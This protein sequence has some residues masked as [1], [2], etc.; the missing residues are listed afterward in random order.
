MTKV[1]NY[2]LVIPVFQEALW[3]MTHNLDFEATHSV[4]LWQRSPY[5]E[6]QSLWPQGHI[7]TEVG[8]E[9]VKQAR[10]HIVHSIQYAKDMKSPRVIKTHMPF[11]FLPEDLLDKCKGKFITLLNF[12]SLI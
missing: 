4:H 1:K 2:I 7:V 9:E 12:L 10:R 6:V 11:E 5:I 3:Q 8:G